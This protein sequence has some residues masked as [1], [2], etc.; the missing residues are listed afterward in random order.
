MAKDDLVSSLPR[1]EAML[2]RCFLVDC[3]GCGSYNVNESLARIMVVCLRCGSASCKVVDAGRT[4][5]GSM[6]RKMMMAGGKMQP[7]IM[8]VRGPFDDESDAIVALSVELGLMMP[9]ASA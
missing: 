3:P 1:V 5:Y 2:E 6:E 8:R 7:T 9:R 4:C